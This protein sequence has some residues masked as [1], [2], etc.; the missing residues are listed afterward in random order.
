MLN[1]RIRTENKQSMHYYSKKL[2]SEQL[3][4]W[5]FMFNWLTKN[6]TLSIFTGHIAFKSIIAG[7]VE[8]VD[9]LA[10]GASGRKLVAV[11]VGFSVPCIWYY[12]SLFDFLLLSIAQYRN[13]YHKSLFNSISCSQNFFNT[14]SVHILHTGTA[15]SALLSR[16]RPFKPQD[17]YQGDL[18]HKLSVS[19]YAVNNCA[20][21]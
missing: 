15:K 5:S 10:S 8:L 3:I 20:I 16:G 14:F 21:F 13:K 9:T 1:L 12:K 19:N 18:R 7:M 17:C 6:Y 2:L 11:R 4:Q